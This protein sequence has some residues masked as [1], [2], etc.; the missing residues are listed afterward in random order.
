MGGG[1]KKGIR[2]GWICEGRGRVGVGGEERE[3][4]GVFGM[5]SFFYHGSI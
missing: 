4:E 1:E 2:V 3:F 5:G